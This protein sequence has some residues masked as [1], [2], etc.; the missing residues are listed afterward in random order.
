MSL[1]TLPLRIQAE[2]RNIWLGERL[3]TV[4]PAVLARAGLDMWLVIAREYN[5]DP[6]IMS[7]LPEPAMSARRRTIL[8]FARRPDGTVERLT[9]DRY[10]HGAYYQRAWDP[11]AE[12]QDACLAR[13]V[14]ERDPQ[15][16]GVNVSE[17]FAFGDGLSHHEHERLLAALGP[18]YAA[19]L[20]SAEAA[21]VGWLETRT[22]AEIS[23]YTPIIA[24][25][26]N[27]IARAFSR[28]VITPGETTTDDVVWWMRQTMHDAGLRAWFHPTVEI[29]APGQRYDA[30]ERRSVIMPG[31]LLH[32]DVGFA[33]MGLCTDQQQHAYVLRAGEAAAPT[34]L[35]HALAEGN[36]LQDILIGAM[37]VGRTGNTVLRDALGQARAAGLS[38]SI[39][40]HPLGYHGHAAGPTIGLWDQQ[41]GVPGNGDYPLYDRTAYSI[42]LNVT[43]ALPEWDDQEVRV[44]LEEDA[45]LSGG[46]VSWLDG[47][48]TELHLI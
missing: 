20:V 48:Q 35:R 4:I 26:H 5:E 24:M 12:S 9:L 31:D 17:T 21:A 43:C 30:E 13:I 1:T 39:Y 8:C 10:G 15:R 33:Y 40:T 23:A 47:R 16:I 27:L 29:Q 41:G 14:A 44:A 18:Q 32:C 37:K 19:R 36:R 3:D 45:L 6:V 25:G 38:P 11:D 28:E 7:L 22:P 34:G 2:V 46:V 42:E